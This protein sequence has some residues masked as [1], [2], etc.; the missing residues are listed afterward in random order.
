MCLGSRRQLLTQK[1]PFRG[2]VGG[3]LCHKQILRQGGC[4]ATVFL[5]NLRGILANVGGWNKV[6]AGHISLAQL[7]RPEAEVRGL[8]DPISGWAP[9]PL[10]DTTFLL[11][12]HGGRSGLWSL[13][14]CKATN[15]IARTPPHD[16]PKAPPPNMVPL[17]VWASTDG[18]AG[19]QVFSP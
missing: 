14:P 13:S 12:P 4:E 11:C 9:L 5:R 8:A 19:R 2:L 6:Q 3:L 16:L 1:P 10:A 18:S 15:P 7:W 17:G